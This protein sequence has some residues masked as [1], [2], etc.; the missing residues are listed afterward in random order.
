MSAHDQHPCP[1]CGTPQYNGGVVQCT[2]CG[3]LYC[4]DNSC[5]AGRGCSVCGNGAATPS[6]WDEINDEWAHQ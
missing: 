1:H 6:T 5:G 2:S 4:G 3:E